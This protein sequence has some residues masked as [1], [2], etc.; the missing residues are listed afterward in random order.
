MCL[1]LWLTGSTCG[2]CSRV[3]AVDIS[4]GIV[5]DDCD[6]SITNYTL[7]PGGQKYY[8]PSC[9]G[10]IEVPFAN[11]IFDSLEKAFKF[12]KEYG[13][14]G[15]FNE[16]KAT[17]KKDSDGTIILKHFVCRNEG[18]NVVNLSSDEKVGKVEGKAYGV[19]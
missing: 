14:L 7:S 4:D 19:S 1:I 13:R 9:V 11:Q 10:S 18:Y 2:D 6:S 8:L 15:G 5:S 3:G 12:Y 17:E 16:W